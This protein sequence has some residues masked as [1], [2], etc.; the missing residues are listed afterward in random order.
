MRSFIEVSGGGKKEREEN[1][2]KEVLKSETLWRKK[3]KIV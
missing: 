2:E 1:S 3:K